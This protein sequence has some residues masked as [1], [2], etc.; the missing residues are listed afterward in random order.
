MG[1]MMSATVAVRWQHTKE[2]M[3]W[4]RYLM[5]DF[6]NPSDELRG[7]FCYCN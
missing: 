6:A 4:G 3:H 5:L 2:F 7:R 1:N